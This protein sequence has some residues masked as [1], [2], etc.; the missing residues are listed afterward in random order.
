MTAAFARA[1]IEADPIAEDIEAEIARA[2]AAFSEQ[3]S[4]VL[5]TSDQSVANA[6]IS[7]LAE[8][9]ARR[10]LTE[11]N[12]RR[13]RQLG[14]THFIWRTQDD[15]KVRAA[16]VER[17]DTVFSW[18]DGFPDGA[19]GHSYNCRCVAEPA[20]V[21]GTILLT[22]V[23]ASPEF[24]DRNARAQA[25]GLADAATDAAVGGA[26]SVYN[27]FRFSWL[28]Y[29]RLFGIITPEEEAERLAMREGV[30]HTIDALTALDEETLRRQAD[31]FV[32]HFDARHADLRLLDLEY[33][34]G[35]ASEETLLRAYR[36]VA[37]MDGATTLGTTAFSTFATR[38]G[39]NLTRLRPRDA[40]V[41]LRSATARMETL[42][43]IRRTN[44]S[45]LVA[46]RFAELEAQGHGPQRHVG[47]VTRQMLIDRVLDGKDP[48]TGT[49]VDGVTGRPH[50]P[51]PI[52]TRITTPEA[53]VAAESYL[54]RTAAYR[55]TRNAALF[56]PMYRR[57]SFSV[58][59]SLDD[60]LGPDY[61]QLVERVRR[62]DGRIVDV[63]FEGGLLLAIVRLEPSG[64]PVLV[65]MYPVGR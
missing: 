3:A 49:S 9:L 43:A 1:G 39:I 15:E 28:G 13:Q 58:V 45:A 47:A 33:R 21:D 30:F 57:G 35:L 10:F 55:A 20:I 48:M 32:D 53:F 63:D 2:R 7:T 52:A 11:I 23:P 17:D 37:Y 19:P 46:R 41:A 8:W 54:R 61:L 38:L 22:H 64:A 6:D 24:N 56:A 60:A 18:Q 59:L 65:T 40:F 14:V 51:P 31:A 29:G 4:V 26:T 34:L 16:H 36:E 42:L 62:A 12:E 25:G 44:V 5:A 27:L 50:R